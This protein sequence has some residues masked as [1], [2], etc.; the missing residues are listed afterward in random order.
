MAT[1]I[2][3]LIRARDEF[4]A[5]VSKAEAQIDALAKSNVELGNATV[6]V[7]QQ[8]SQAAGSLS[9]LAEG[10]KRV[11]HSFVESNEAARASGELIGITLPRYVSSF[12]A[13]SALIGPALESAFSG[14]AVIG[15]IQVLGELPKAF[16]KIKASITGWTETAKKAYEGFITD[17]EKAIDRV[18]KLNAALAGIHAPKGFEDIARRTEEVTAAQKAFNEA[19]AGVAGKLADIKT[20]RALEAA[21]ADTGD[22]LRSAPARESSNLTQMGKELT[23]LQVKAFKAAA[24]LREAQDALREA[25]ETNVVDTSRKAGEEFQK[26]IEQEE[27][28]RDQQKKIWQGALTEFE[29]RTAGG[30]P[31]VAASLEEA[32]H[33]AEG[34]A[35]AWQ[36]IV[37]LQQEG[38]DQLQKNRNEWDK[39]LED[40]R[41]KGGSEEVKFFESTT[42]Q[43]VKAILKPFDE[44]K[45]RG[46]EIIKDITDDIGRMFTDSIVHGK[47]FWDAF[48]RL[49]LDAVAAV[50]NALLKGLVTQG[51]NSL[52]GGVIGTSSGLGKL[53]GLG[54][55]VLGG[56]SAAAGGAATGAFTS[57]GG[58]TL[59]NT[60]FAANSAVAAPAAFGGG[61]GGAL[62]LGGGAGLFG[63]GAATIPV[64]GAIALGI[65]GLS[66]LFGH[67][68]QEAPFTRDPN[69]SQERTYFFYAANEMAD[70][71]RELAGA[72]KQLKG[73][74]PNDV[75]VKG[76]PGALQQSN[77][78]RRNINGVLQDDI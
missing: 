40:F 37:K 63:L 18:N 66:K 76:L 48:K 65:F 19:Q 69:V 14:L 36:D 56:V 39:A 67:H 49:G 27:E 23:D 70:A 43:R 30:G 6:R 58:T 64:I 46:K 45:K 75:V 21:S 28:F 20:Q 7:S 77:Q 41:I 35:K 47:N 33:K 60:G 50:T 55:S 15:L 54:G 13:R 4:S 52:L 34:Y 12:L 16:D 10:A 78:F 8:S 5:V 44:A 38:G 3:I 74:N 57:I 1:P 29:I 53:L 71:S 32:R 72:T 25:T 31:D 42:E 9:S 26:L 2:D 24:T 61:I 59:L 51:L 73:I 62:G 11:G 68:T 17:N 22:R